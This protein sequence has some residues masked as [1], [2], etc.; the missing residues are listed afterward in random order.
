MSIL[1]SSIFFFSYC[2]FFCSICCFLT[3]SSSFVSLSAYDTLTSSRSQWSPNPSFLNLPYYV[4]SRLRLCRQ[5]QTQSC[6]SSVSFLSTHISGRRLCPAFLEVFLSPPQ[7]VFL[8]PVC[9]WARGAF[10][11]FEPFLRRWSFPFAHQIRF[12]AAPG[13]RPLYVSLFFF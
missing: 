7:V 5:I 6:S 13:A 2:Y 10:F 3:F 12:W 1:L 8:P 11:L 9:G 4:E